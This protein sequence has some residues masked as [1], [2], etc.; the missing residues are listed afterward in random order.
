MKRKCNFVYMIEKATGKERNPSPDTIT[1]RP[2]QKYN[3][4]VVSLMGLANRADVSL[5]KYILRLLDKHVK[6][7]SK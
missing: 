7:K 6:D 4:I 5:N 2:G 1:I 3:G